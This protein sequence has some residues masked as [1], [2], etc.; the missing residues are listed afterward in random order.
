MPVGVLEVE[1][2]EELGFPP[3][4]FAP[5]VGVEPLASEDEDGLDD[6]DDVGWDV[7]ADEAADDEVVSVAAEL[8]VEEEAGVEEEIGGKGERLDTADSGIVETPFTTRSVYI[9]GMRRY[10]TLTF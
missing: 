6:D 9:D 10:I 3:A 2:A 5:G 1:D 7:E 8:D 4:A